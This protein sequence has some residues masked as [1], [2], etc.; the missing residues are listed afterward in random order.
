MRSLLFAPAD[1]PELLAKL[2]RAAPDAV[3][4]DLEDGVAAD[5]KDLARAGLADA[6]AGL[7]G[8]GVQ[9]TVRIN[10]VESEHFAADAAAIPDGVDLV[11]VPKLETAEQVARVAAALPGMP[12]LAGIETA[13]GV[14]DVGEVLTGPVTSAYFGAEDYVADLGG[15]RTKH[16][17]EVLYARSRVAL[18]CRVRGVHALDQ[19]VV[20]IRDDDAFAR[21]ARRGRELGYRGKLCVHPGQVALA[22]A[23]FTPT[24]EEVARARALLDAAEGQGVV[25]FEGAMVDE[26]MLR[27]ARDVIARASRRPSRDTDDRRPDG[28]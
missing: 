24:A 28:R 8:S 7:A 1:R 21:D 19:V 10:A 3:C 27:A 5:R 16:S 20:D 14:F 18:A 12:L 4:I 23:A 17:E 2:P 15:L 13:R 26:P 22:H 25:V 6:V 9:V 11:V